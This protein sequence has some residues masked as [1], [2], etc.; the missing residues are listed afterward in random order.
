MDGFLFLFGVSMNVAGALVVRFGTTS[1]LLGQWTV[2]PASRYTICCTS[3]KFTLFTNRKTV[4]YFC[5]PDVGSGVVVCAAV[6][7]PQLVAVDAADWVAKEILVWQAFD[8][9]GVPAVAEGLLISS[10][11]VPAVG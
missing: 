5:M 9:R 8:H 7:S 1:Q 11:G 4:L 3:F 2:T 10:Q 6:V